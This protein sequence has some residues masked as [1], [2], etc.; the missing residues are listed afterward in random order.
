MASNELYGTVEQEGDHTA[1]LE[2]GADSAETEPIPEGFG[3]SL[4]SVSGEN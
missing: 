4:S 1:E 2:D 3:S